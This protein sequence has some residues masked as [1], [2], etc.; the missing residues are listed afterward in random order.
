M[1]RFYSLLLF[2]LIAAVN[3]PALEIIAIVPFES[4]AVGEINM[5]D[6][7]R[8]LRQEMV[9]Y[10]LFQTIIV[11]DA[12]ANG[13]AQPDLNDR[14]AAMG[15]RLNAGRLVLGKLSRTTD[16]CR[17]QIQLFDVETRRICYVRTF[18]D[19]A[20]RE[21]ELLHQCAAYIALQSE[22]SITQRQAILNEFGFGSLFIRS[23]P[24]G[25][26]IVL[27]SVLYGQTPRMVEGLPAGMYMVMLTK[28]GY[29]QHTEMVALAPDR[30]GHVTA[31]L[32]QSGTDSTLVT[33]NVLSNKIALRFS[34]F[35]GAIVGAGIAGVLAL[36]QKSPDQATA[37]VISA[38]LA[39]ACLAGFSFVYFW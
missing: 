9:G 13:Y 28:P 34:L 4:V 33:D 30:T 32:I 26:R 2:L 29:K 38:C 17:L 16:S 15:E 37:P 10:N 21:R 24:S 19:V 22:L 25:A 23:Q 12:L 36:H 20:M 35:S 6:L 5:G 14:F 11:E 27:D 7:E 31:T 39:G 8:T 3:I 18:A 1:K